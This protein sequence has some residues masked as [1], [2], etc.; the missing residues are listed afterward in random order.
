VNARRKAPCVYCSAAF[1][2][3]SVVPCCFYFLP[4]LAARLDTTTIASFSCEHIECYSTQQY[5]VRLCMHDCRSNTRM[6]TRAIIPA[7]AKAKLVLPAVAATRNP[8]KKTQHP[9]KAPS[10]RI[11]VRI[12]EMDSAPVAKNSMRPLPAMMILMTSRRRSRME[13]TIANPLRS[14]DRY[15]ASKMLGLGII[16]TLAER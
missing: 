16:S 8:R 9:T 13:S 12:L 1:R 3:S 4:V 2:I 5:H 7:R 14:I 11:P 10:F 6:T 15:G